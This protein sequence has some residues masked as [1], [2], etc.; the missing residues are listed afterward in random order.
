MEP[1]STLRI[2]HEIFTFFTNPGGHSL[3]LRGSAGAGKTTFALQTMEDLSELERSYY[4]STRVS[5]DSLFTQFPWLRRKVGRAS[6]GLEEEE[7]NPGSSR[8]DLNNLKGF[9]DSALGMTNGELSV[10]LGRELRDIEAIYDAV[11]SNL[12]E[13]SLVVIDSVDAMAEKYDMSCS[14]LINTMQKDVVEHY[15]A[16]ALFVLENADS[17]LD[18][19]GDGVVMLCIK[20][21][22]RRRIREI[23]LLKLRGCE[24]FQPKY[25]YT[26][27]EGKIKSFGLNGETRPIDPGCWDP[28]QDRDG[29]VSTGIT[30]LDRLMGGGLERGS[31]TLVELGEGI[32]TS[33]TK[34]LEASLVSNFTSLGRGVLWVPLRKASPESAKAQVMGMVEENDFSRLVRIPVSASQLNTFESRFVMAVEG[35]DASADLSWKNIEYSLQDAGRPVLSL[36]GF[37][38]MES[39]YGGDLMDKLMGHLAAIKGNDGVF[40]G[41]TSPSARSTERLAD[42]ANAHIKI[43]RIGGTIIIYGE[44]PFTAC[45]A[46]TYNQNE[47]GGC[48]TLTQIV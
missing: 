45:N 48:V 30:D 42:L 11:E 17:Q 12:P 22:Q 33:F 13:R 9:D 31:I 10:S 16:N 29:R 20:E 43:D 23:D 28:I 47:K 35:S 26:L 34:I 24:I 2:P 8:T 21:Y 39:I 3:I 19:L 40:V 44:E 38:T 32:P 6:V 5:D 36:A 4:V 41:I 15:G 18:Y 25:L 37:D 27:K 14:K 7:A 46:I 1:G